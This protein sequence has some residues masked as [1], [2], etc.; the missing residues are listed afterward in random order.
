MVISKEKLALIKGIIEKNSK[1][2]VISTLGR[3]VFTQKEINAMRKEGIDVSNADSFLELIYNYAFLNEKNSANKP[4][5]GPDAQAQQAVPGVKP[6][7]DAHDA[8]VEHLNEMAKVSLDK[9]QQDTTSRIEGIIRDSNNSYRFN[10]LQNLDRPESFDNLVKQS[11]VG[12][13]KQELRDYTKEANRNWA[14]VAT[15]EVSN[16]IGLGATDRIVSQNRDK[17]PE[18]VYVYRIV[19]NDQALCK[20]CDRFYQ[21]DDGSPKVYRL[22]TLLDNGSNYGKKTAEWNPVVGATHPNDRESGPIQL[23]PGWEVLPG[24]SQK[25]IGLTEWDDYILNKLSN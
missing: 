21:D 18:E 6:V 9:L 17:K 5:S 2:F 14:R 8:A 19:V 20:W 13:I 7:G 16:S 24:G 10:A 1:A 22:S 4:T 23:K 3:S 15:T 11:S 25:F 12:K